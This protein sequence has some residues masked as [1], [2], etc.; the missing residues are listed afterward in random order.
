MP[1]SLQTIARVRHPPVNLCTSKARLWTRWACV[2]LT[3]GGVLGGAPGGVGVDRSWGRAV[4]GLGQGVA[5]GLGRRSAHEKAAVEPI[6]DHLDNLVPMTTLL[7]AATSSARELERA[8]SPAKAT[9]LAILKARATVVDEATAASSTTRTTKTSKSDTLIVSSTSHNALDQAATAAATVTVSA[10]ATSSSTSSSTSTKSA[11]G[12]VTAVPSGYSVP[13]AFD[14]TLGTNFTSTAC[15]SF[16]QTFLADPDF[17]A[18]APFSL[19]LAT[20]SAFF[21]AQQSPDV[22]LPF[23]MNATCTVNQTACSAIMDDYAT[24]IRAAST[25]GPDLTKRNPL[26]VEALSGFQNYNMMY[27]A[28]CLQNNETGKV[29]DNVVVAIKGWML[30]GEL[31]G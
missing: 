13:G 7:T 19:L 26:V 31:T 21:K 5:S 14:S 30:H 23:V 16:F 15:P 2:L 27:D 20:S 28:G 24:Q 11:A 9:R 18:C 1:H 4:G 25:C 22:L 29:S 17:I 8:S 12:A 3:V 6:D 10:S